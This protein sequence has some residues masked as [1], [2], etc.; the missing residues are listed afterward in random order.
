MTMQK[1]Q[2]CA[3]CINRRQ[4][5]ATTVAGAAGLVVTGCGDGDLSGVTG[6]I[7]PLPSGPITITV[8]D[9]AGLATTGVLVM[10]QDAIGVKRTGPNTFDAFSLFCTHQGCR[11]TIT[12]NTQLDCPCH[13]SRFDGDGAVVRG[14]A[15]DPLPRYT[16][17]Y[18]ASTDTLTIG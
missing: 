6:P 3:E 8:G 9:H 17:S 15:K 11:V 1:P 16:T 5:L 14:P 10:I 13:F 12:T 18:N 7:V 4:F 2:P